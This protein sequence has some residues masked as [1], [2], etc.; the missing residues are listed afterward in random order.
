[1]CNLSLCQNS[2]TSNKTR[3]AFLEKSYG[4]F[5]FE[6]IEK[7]I[8][9]FLD[10]EI[11]LISPCTIFARIRMNTTYQVIAMIHDKDYATYFAFGYVSKI[12]LR[13]K[14]TGA[15]EDIRLTI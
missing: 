11:T 5:E 6:S 14:H 7:A 10:K 1:M 13:R 2:K 4:D 8:E 3:V 9:N 12:C 15:W